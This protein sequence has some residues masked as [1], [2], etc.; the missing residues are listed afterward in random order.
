MLYFIYGDDTKK[1]RQ[2]TTEMVDS[3]LRRQS[4]ASV[5]R[6]GVDNWNLE[7]V[8]DLLNSQGL[9]LPKYIVIFNFIS[10]NKEFFADLLR[11]LPDIKKTEHVCIISEGD[12]SVKDEEKIKKFS[13][14]SQEF[15]AVNSSTKIPAKKNESP[16]FAFADS[17]A[18]RDFL[19]SMKCFTEMTSSKIAAEEIHGVL[20]W[21]MKSIKL[22]TDSQSAVGAGLNPFVFKKAKEAS[23]MWQDE[24][25]TNKSTLDTVLNELFEMYHLAHRGEGD[26]YTAL[27]KLVVRWGR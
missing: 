12:I 15:S 22:A 23:K 9:F 27:E 1:V 20:W 13:Q 8:N 18:R 5:Y 21:Q 6:V 11:I 3:L 14:K 16:T 10:E 17:F 25:A 26:F 2:K 4:D 24:S 19:K 7:Y